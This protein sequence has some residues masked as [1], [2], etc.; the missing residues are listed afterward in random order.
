MLGI[1]NLARSHLPRALTI[2]AK[3]I[4]AG[5]FVIKKVIPERINPKIPRPNLLSAVFSAVPI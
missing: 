4:D 5:F 2:G 1:L 3:A